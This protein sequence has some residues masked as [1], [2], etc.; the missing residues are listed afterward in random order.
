M[1][2][3]LSNLEM[4]LYNF[5]DDG[6]KYHGRQYFPEGISLVNEPV[7]ENKPDQNEVENQ[8]EVEEEVKEDKPKKRTKKK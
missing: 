4:Y 5:D 7:K 1:Y 2:S 6:K 3:D 8:D